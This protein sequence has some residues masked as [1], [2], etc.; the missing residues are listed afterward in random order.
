MDRK[1]GGLEPAEGQVN[2]T[3]SPWLLPASVLNRNS[4]KDVTPPKIRGNWY[5][6]CCDLEKKFPELFLQLL[7]M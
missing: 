4:G 1:S 3:G 2:F 7:I 5:T 6:V